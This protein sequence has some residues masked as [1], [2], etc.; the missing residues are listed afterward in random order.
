VP[1]SPST[2]QC[3][4]R[5]ATLV[6][7][8]TLQFSF[9]SGPRSEHSSPP[10]LALAGPDF[11]CQ[12]AYQKA[13][14]SFIVSKIF[15]RRESMKNRIWNSSRGLGGVFCSLFRVSLS[16]PRCSPRRMQRGFLL[17]HNA[18]HPLS[19]VRDLVQRRSGESTRPNAPE[20]AAAC[21]RTFLGRNT[22]TPRRLTRHV[23][24][25]GTLS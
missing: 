13:I 11:N 5:H 9:T 23:H 18:V 15:F 2:Q 24:D 7:H 6:P 16:A 22:T 25:T 8:R 10:R 3:A 14:C 4:G 17:T 19:I 21:L 12:A 20:M 1:P